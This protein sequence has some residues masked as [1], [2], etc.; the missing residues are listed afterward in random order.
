MKFFIMS[1]LLMMGISKLHIFMITISSMILMML[2]IFSKIHVMQIFSS[3]IMFDPISTVLML[4]SL[5]TIVL[6]L[7]ST[8][9]NKETNLML[10]SI[11]ILLIL[12]FSSS[13]M[14]IFYI[15][16]E[17]VLI[18]TMILISKSGPQPE[19][20]QASMYLMLYTILAS[21]PMFL[22]ILMCNSFNSFFAASILIKK[23][24]IPLMFMLAF[25]AKT[26][27]YMI[28]LW[29]PKAHVEA[30]L[31]GSMILAAIL[32]KLGGYG[33]I[34]F[35]PM[36]IFSL[37]TIPNWI[38]SISLL[39]A[40]FTSGGCLRQKDLKALIAYSSVAHMGVTLASI[41]IL[42]KMSIS[43]AIIMM[44]AHG[45]S[46]S[47]LFFLVNMTYQKYHTRNIISMKSIYMI[48]PNLS[49][50][51][52]MFIMANLSAPPTLNLMGELLMTMTLIKW[53]I[54]STIPITIIM[55]TTTSF[56][57]ILFLM[58][59]HGKSILKISN[60]DSMKFFLSLIIHLIL[61]ILIILKM[62]PMTLL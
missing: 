25:L 24:F 27:M 30:P 41:M 37:K 40:I 15:F 36:S 34:R 58:L 18:P 39:G 8:N 42:M 26:P 14:I 5:F 47:A 16:F 62:E 54:F 43:G 60:N 38:I 52:F 13:K 20:L 17:M 49:F 23:I 61:S 50:W 35:L 46:S 57:I 22:G 53:S 9:M 2:I 29:L 19:R 10:T 48:N 45:V 55:M 44:I 7:L 21:L 56:C 1:I 28:H 31:E 4:L 59:N 32:L 6:I 33:L 12:T 11:L 3:M 51:W